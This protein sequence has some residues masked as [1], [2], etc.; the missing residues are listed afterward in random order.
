MHVP[1]ISAFLAIANIFY[2]T[3]W[4]DLSSMTDC[5]MKGEALAGWV[6]LLSRCLTGPRLNLPRCSGF[7]AFVFDNT[8]RAE[9]KF[10]VIPGDLWWLLRTSRFLGNAPNFFFGRYEYAG[11]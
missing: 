2:E 5:G 11:W 6:F 7:D 4:V 9:K 1:D 10:G 3:V 8:V